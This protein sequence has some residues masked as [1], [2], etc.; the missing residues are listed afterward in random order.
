[1]EKTMKCDC[2]G[3]T[4]RFSRYCAAFVCEDCGA[5]VDLVR[6]YC[7]WS[8]SGGNGREELEEMGETIEEEQ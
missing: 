4:A 8:A 2:C 5:H 1:M 6:C 3:K 7:G